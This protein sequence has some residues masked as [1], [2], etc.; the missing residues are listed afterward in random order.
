MI[1]Y[2]L[3]FVTFSRSPDQSSDAQ[4]QMP[5]NMVDIESMPQL[6]GLRF[7]MWVSTDNGELGSKCDTKRQLDPLNIG[8]SHL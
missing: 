1:E 3:L 7:N 8:Q 5:E 2:V 6:T 4:Y